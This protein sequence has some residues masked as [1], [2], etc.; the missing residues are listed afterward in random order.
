MIKLV[1]SDM[2]G[3]LLDDRKQIDPDIYEVL[4]RLKE[5]RIRF[6]VASGRQY[7]SLLSLF[8][9]HRQDVV[10][11]AENGAYVTYDGQ[12]LYSSV[13]KRDIVEYSL[14]CIGKMPNV[15][16]MLCAR[17]VSYTTNPKTYEIMKSDKFKYKMQL[18][19]NLYDVKDEIIKV[20][21]LDYDKNGAEGNSFAFLKPLLHQKAEIAVSGFQC[22]DI[23]NKGVSKGT[24]IEAMQ[25]RWGISMEETVA[26]G[27][28]YN[29]VEMLQRAAYSFAMANA[30]PGVQKVA[31]YITGSNNE[32]SVVKEI[33]K[34]AGI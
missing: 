32:G 18:V 11:I 34:L 9:A 12:E 5:K 33:R 30:E 13:M 27:D 2:D 25:K 26:F 17:E 7:P 6:M 31:R 24:A 28:N 21:M 8:H 19:D 10:I 15:E 4:E 20:S 22:V 3:T 14:D 16:P 29:D 1:V 23:V